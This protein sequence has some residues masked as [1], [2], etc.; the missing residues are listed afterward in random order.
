MRGW[1]GLLLDMFPLVVWGLLIV[2]FVHSIQRH[3]RLDREEK[4]KNAKGLLGLALFA[5][6][7]A[8]I[9]VGS[10]LEVVLHSQLHAISAEDVSN[11]KVGEKQ[12]SNPADIA[13]I[14]NDLKQSEWYAVSHGGWGDETPMV[15]SFKS[16]EVW[17]LSVGYHF[18]QQGA[19]IA[20]HRGDPNTT[21][22]RSDVYLFS[23]TLP[24]TLRALG[25]PVSM[26]DTAHGRPCSTPLELRAPRSA[27]PPK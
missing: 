18:S 25:A 4:L 3:R 26:C 8:A 7:W 21:G 14:V 20:K 23:E 9:S 16:G 1:S 2:A 5:I 6:L 24:E 10:V 19:V 27:N 12:F 13:Q 15:I 22:F 11:I 17:F